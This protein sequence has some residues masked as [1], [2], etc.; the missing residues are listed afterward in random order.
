MFT[1]T[2]FFLFLKKKEFKKKPRI[3]A[4]PEN[5]TIMKEASVERQQ[6]RWTS[7]G[8][9]GILGSWGGGADCAYV[10]LGHSVNF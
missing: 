5:N 8:A 6:Y 7:G 4:F 2:F 10:S 1:E 3:T 9:P